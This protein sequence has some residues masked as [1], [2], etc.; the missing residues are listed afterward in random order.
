MALILA[1]HRHLYK[2]FH[3][4]TPVDFGVRFLIV[5]YFVLF[6]LIYY[7]TVYMSIELLKRK[8]P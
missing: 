4:L 7:T 6:S 5:L 3:G 8:I 1:W 2:A